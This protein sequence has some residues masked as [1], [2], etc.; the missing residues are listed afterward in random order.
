MLIDN[1]G[2]GRISRPDISTNYAA[3]ALARMVLMEG[4]MK[5]TGMGKMTSDMD[6]GGV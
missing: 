4:L 5:M 1:P 2:V 3:T 6:L